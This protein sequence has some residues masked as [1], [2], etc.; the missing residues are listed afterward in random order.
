MTEK[1]DYII[2]VDFVIDRN[3][4]KLYSNVSQTSSKRIKKNMSLLKNLLI[5][6]I[7]VI[8]DLSFIV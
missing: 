2:L 1:I 5:I 4:S 6:R 7:S 8:T 3:Y